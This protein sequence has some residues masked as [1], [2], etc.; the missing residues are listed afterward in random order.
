[1]YLPF[2]IL[3]LESLNFLYTPT[4]EKDEAK[5][6]LCVRLCCTE[7][8]LKNLFWF[9]QEEMDSNFVSWCEY[10]GKTPI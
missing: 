5:E 7:I 6:K 9:D 10:V 1:M 4:A 2:N 8:L 3:Q